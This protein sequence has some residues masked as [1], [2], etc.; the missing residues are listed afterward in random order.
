M[1]SFPPF[2]NPFSHH[3][4]CNGTLSTIQSGLTG[5]VCGFVFGSISYEFLLSSSLLTKDEETFLYHLHRQKIL[6]DQ[7]HTNLI[8]LQQYAKLSRRL[9][10][11]LKRSSP[12]SSFSPSSSSFSPSS[13]SSSPSSSS[14]SSPSSSSSSSVRVS[15]S[16]QERSLLETQTYQLQERQDQLWNYDRFLRLSFKGVEKDYR[17]RKLHSFVFLPFSYC[18]SLFMKSRP[19]SF[20]SHASSFSSSLSSTSTPEVQ[21]TLLSSPSRAS[22]VIASKPPSSTAGAAASTLSS[23]ASSASTS[24]QS[25]LTGHKDGRKETRFSRRIHCRFHL[26]K[27]R[28]QVFSTDQIFLRLRVGYKTGVAFMVFYAMESGIYTWLEK[29]EGST[30]Y[31]RLTDWALSALYL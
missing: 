12:S 25:L 1:L 26:W 31:T 20:L 15:S 8:V 9:S 7:Q 24:S 19:N 14:S 16:P 5:L 28:L 27:R 6:L 23:S 13:S 3:E 17:Q 22:T 4:N 21:S 18:R 29:D 30:L 10:L 11:A 2:R